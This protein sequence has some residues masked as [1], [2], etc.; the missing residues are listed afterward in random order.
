MQDPCKVTDFN[1]KKSKK[2]QRSTDLKLG[3][4]SQEI[5]T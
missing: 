2:I 5:V 1:C 4:F 3:E